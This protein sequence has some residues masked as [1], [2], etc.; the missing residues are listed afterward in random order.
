MKYATL[1]RDTL[2]YR[3]MRNLLS[4]MSSRQGRTFQEAKEFWLN[5]LRS[6]AISAGESG[7][8]AKMISLGRQI[9]LLAD[10]DEAGLK[11]IKAE[12]ERR[13]PL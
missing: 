2:E 7:N 11:R 13:G 3:N 4:S 12:F 1:D 10:L 5:T 9:E 6:L 8:T